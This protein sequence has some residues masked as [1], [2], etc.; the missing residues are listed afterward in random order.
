[1]VTNMLALTFGL[2]GYWPMDLTSGSE[3]IDYSPYL[4]HGSAVEGA[5]QWTTGKFGNALEI[6]QLRDD[7]ATIPH[8]EEYNTN[9]AYSLSL[10]FRSV[11][12][13][14]RSDQFSKG[15]GLVAVSGVGSNAH[16]DAFGTPWT[17]SDLG[18]DMNDGLW[19]HLVFTFDAAASS[20][21]HVYVDG[22]LVAS[23][24]SVGVTDPAL[25]T[26]PMGFGSSDDLE[27]CMALFDEVAI[28]NRVITPAEINH[29]YNGGAGNIVTDRS[30][31]PTRPNHVSTV[32]SN[33]IVTLTWD[34]N[35]IDPDLGGYRVYRANASGGPYNLISG[36]L[37]LNHFADTNLTNYTPYY[38]IVRTVNTRGLESIDSR[39]VMGFPFVPLKTV[40]ANGLVGYW[41]MDNV[42][43]TEIT[44]MT[45]FQNDGT[46]L[47]GSPAWVEGKFGNALVGLELTRVIVITSHT[48]RN[49]VHF[50]RLDDLVEEPVQPDRPDLPKT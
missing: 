28:W 24:G 42:N 21:K 12:G 49:A 27:K 29:L 41:P 37:N 13:I 22:V 32:S 25:N 33:Q 14:G 16:V 17:S 31:P 47:Q 6:S 26:L 5:P 46:F 9:N 18:F 3:L 7:R 8:L 38:Y 34:A 15:E 45:A 2:V 4:N 50:H 23:A 10:W 1:M 36:D 30:L 43:G 48:F 44:D 11:D 40:L 20:A 39:E 35:T 19:H